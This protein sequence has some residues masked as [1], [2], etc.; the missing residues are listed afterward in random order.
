[1]SD[2]SSVYKICPQ[3]GQ[4]VSEAAK[5]CP[6][7]GSPFSEDN[8]EFV[9]YERFPTPPQEEAPAPAIN[10]DDTV[11]FSPVE[12]QG[13]PLQF[14]GVPQPPVDG[15]MD[16]SGVAYSGPDRSGNSNLG[17]PRPM[18]APGGSVMDAFRKTA[19]AGGRT[20]ADS[21]RRSGEAAD[22]GGLDGPPPMGGKAVPDD[23]NRKK[24][25]VVTVI[26]AVILVA[27]ITVGVVMAFQLG[28]VGG[29]E[30]QDPMTLA[31]EA[32]DQKDFE[33]AIA[34]LEQM[35]A[36]N[37]ATAETYTLLAQA[38]EG[39][40]DME[41]AAAAYLSGATA[42]DDATLKKHAQ[43]SYLRLAQEAQTAGNNEKARE[44]YN[45][46]VEKLDPSN[47]TA[48]AGLSKIG[49]ET[50]SVSPSP[51]PVASP[52]PKVQ[53]SPGITPPTTSAKVSSNVT[54]G[55]EIVVT[56]TA[57]P[58]PT[59]TPT[60]T[61][62]PTATPKPT[63]TP[64]PKPTPTPTP[65]PSTESFNGH[66]YEVVVSD[67]TWWGCKEAAEAAGGHLVSINSQE[68]FNKCASLAA[69]NGL[70]FVRINGYQD[71]SGNWGWCN[72]DAWSF[73]AW[74]PGEPSADVGEDYLCMFSVSGTW[75]FNNTTDDVSE[76]S[77]R[78]GYIIEYDS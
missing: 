46:V 17:Q 22:G 48:I 5:F 39:K 51:S 71:D 27:V 66:R 13:S 36:D 55:N 69:A 76:Y 4:S 40:G 47:A 3:C 10:L 19:E 15:G 30:P 65:T 29:N 32:Y 18:G 75:Y 74:Y 21:A 28:I 59:P 50:L 37:T 57:T 26:A 9:A 54:E 41:A 1:M 72:G 73:T 12:A 70:I 44:Y 60:A 45:L 35:I 42:L 58:S 38:Y 64:T 23:G 68:E 25:L 33:Q 52:N 8:Q 16:A 49:K 67:M 53:T 31:Q 11:R 6:S 34:Q 14:G 78:K 77:G 61:P 43:D 2:A 62:A 20:M 56:P 63:A 24:G 7:C